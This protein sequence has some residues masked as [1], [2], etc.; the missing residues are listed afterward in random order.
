MPDT[1]S[2]DIFALL[3]VLFFTAS[4]AWGDLK[5]MI[6]YLLGRTSYGGARH[7]K[8][9]R[10]LQ[11]Y[12]LLMGLILLPLGY[13]W[14]AGG[15]DFFSP[16]LVE[17]SEG[18]PYWV[19]VMLNTLIAFGIGVVLWEMGLWAAGDAKIFALLALSVPLM[20]YKN[21][22]FSYFPSFVLLF[23]TFVALFALLLVEFV[24]R[25]SRYLLETRGRVLKTGAVSTW[26]ALKSNKKKYISIL[27]MFLAIF[28]L[29][30]ILRHF[31]Q[32]SIDQYLHLNKTV[33]FVILAIV[34]HPLARFA[35]K[36]PVAIT[37]VSIVVAYILYGVFLDET[38]KALYELINIGWFAISIIA[39]RTLYD[40]YL[41]ATDTEQIPV[42]ELR[43]GMLLTQEEQ[44]AFK[45]R[46][47]LYELKIQSF[48]PDG[49][50]QGQAEA[51]TLWCQENQKETVGV[52]RT[53]P[54]APALFIGT[55]LTI[56]FQGLMIVL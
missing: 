19:A 25:T 21:N 6:P 10:R 42:A 8:I 28:T 45:E 32:D 2:Y 4:A 35:Q 7:G 46:Q 15:L 41:K 26:T 44:R 24:H 49:L 12:W 36:K 22:Y 53:I 31:A 52:S 40:A 17:Q 38:G 3:P 43:A 9:P 47:Q 39:F 23:N 55:I 51:I 27:L 18:L 37:A 29:I 54:F 56:L 30:R 33:V 34:F 1:F 50:N 5:P 13:L 48:N 14:L 20:W 16:D 11:A